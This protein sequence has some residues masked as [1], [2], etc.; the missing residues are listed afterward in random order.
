MR[1]LSIFALGFLALSPAAYADEIPAESALRAATVYSSRTMLTRRAVVDIP[2]GAHTVVFKNMPANLLTDSLRAEG[3]AAADVTLGALASRVVASA[4]LVAPKEKELNDQMEL[5]QDQRRAVESEKQALAARQEFLTTLGRQAG[6]RT[7]EDIAEINL[8]P[9]QWTAAAKTVYDGMAETLKAQLAQDIVL[10]AIDRQIQ[11]IQ[12]DMNQLHTGQR[13]TY[14][15][16]LP[17]EAKA[18]T[19]LTVDISYQ[20]PDASW[21]PLY[22]ARLDTKEE[23]LELV[24]YGAV[25]QATGEDWKNIALTLSTAQP[26]R[27]AGLPDLNTMW[28]NLYQNMNVQRSLG[29]AMFSSDGVGYS[30]VSSGASME[31]ARLNSAPAFVAEEKAAQFQSATI[32]TGGFVSEYK[33]PG[34]ATVKADGTESKLMIGT[35]DTENEIRIQV[36]PQISQEAF[37]VTHTKL[38]GESP[39]L[40]GPVSLFRDGAFVGQANLPLLRPG[41]ESDLAFGVD[42]QVSVRRRIMKDQRSEAGLIAKDSILERNF[43]TELQNL[44]SKPI[45]IVVLETMPVAQDKL[46]NVLVVEDKT[47]PGYLKDPDNVKGLMRWAVPLEPKAKSEVSLG[48]K[49][50]WPKDQN[51][52]GI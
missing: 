35:F 37:L 28:I 29:K 26:E 13:T 48:W 51:I 27:A 36:K 5:L 1:A 43:V 23:K 44:H 38:K 49:V 12:T 34:P 17:L 2:A 16:T 7:G 15:V 42:N 11:K 47:T 31:S 30:N 9:E 24:Q 52:S 4:D 45:T 18:A 8:K 14:E 40:A 32:E 21:T 19:R 25:H 6:L 33:I 41:E 22:D 39:I 3:T 50:S 46:I 10:R 20:V